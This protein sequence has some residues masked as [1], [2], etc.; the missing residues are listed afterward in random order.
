MSV[1]SIANEWWEVERVESGCWFD[2]VHGGARMWMVLMFVEEGK[3]SLEI[4]RRT[5]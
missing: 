2:G 3:P 5:T 1:V 4:Q